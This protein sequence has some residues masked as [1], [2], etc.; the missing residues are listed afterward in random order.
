MRSGLANDSSPPV[1]TGAR[2]QAK[3]TTEAPTAVAAQQESKGPERPLSEPAPG[4]EPGGAGA[5]GHATNDPHTAR[6]RRSGMSPTGAPRV[7]GATQ[8]RSRGPT[9]P[10]ADRRRALLV[11]QIGDCEERQ[12][13]HA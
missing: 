10:Y 5:G 8:E 9:D 1:D 12:A 13:L 2:I 11:E 6:R 3:V 7:E 4:A